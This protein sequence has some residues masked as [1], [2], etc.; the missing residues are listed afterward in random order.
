MVSVDVKQNSNNNSSIPPSSFSPSLISLMVSVDVKHHAYFTFRI[1][2]DKS[3]V[4]VLKNGGQRYI[5]AINNMQA[6]QS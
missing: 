4:S 2:C 3:A 6:K 5:K 1:R